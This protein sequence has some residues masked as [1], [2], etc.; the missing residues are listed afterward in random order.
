[1]AS[2]QDIVAQYGSNPAELSYQLKLRAANASADR[3]E[4]QSGTKYLGGNTRQS[5][6]QNAVGLDPASFGGGS[7]PTP[8]PT[9][10]TPPPS[11]PTAPASTDPAAT[12]STPTT[13][14]APPPADTAG[15]AAP[16]MSSPTAA[17]SARAQPFNPA[18]MN[19]PTSLTSL[20]RRAGGTPY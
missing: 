6:I 19:T 16:V 7:A 13:P 9:S 20:F 18:A 8:A 10:P 5:V 3:N 17:L 4:A 14:Q 2:I 12:P 15:S 11:Q 1:M